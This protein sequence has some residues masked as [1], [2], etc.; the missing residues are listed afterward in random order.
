MRRPLGGADA[1]ARPFRLSGFRG[2]PPH[3]IID[4]IK[5]RKPNAQQIATL[6][7]RSLL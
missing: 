6:L 2:S 4:V 1:A 5:K 7:S 3:R